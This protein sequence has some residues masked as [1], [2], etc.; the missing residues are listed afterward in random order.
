MVSPQFA[1]ACLLIRNPC[2]REAKAASPI[3]KSYLQKVLAMSQAEHNEARRAGMQPNH[4]PE[5]QDQ[6]LDSF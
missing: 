4:C 5:N 6:R 3:S 1:D 2:D